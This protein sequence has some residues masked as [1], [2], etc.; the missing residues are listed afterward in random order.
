MPGGEPRPHRKC[1]PGVLALLAVALLSQTPAVESYRAESAR[2]GL[3][4]SQLSAEYSR[5]R[6]QRVRAALLARAQRA[7]HRSIV[8]TL[9][10]SWFGT[11]W[12]MDG[13]SETPGEGF[14]ACS[15]L[16]S[17]ILRDAGFKVQRYKLAQAASEQIVRSLVPRARVRRMTTGRTEDVLEELRSRG[18][19]LYLVG[20]DYHVGF[21]ILEGERADFCHS[22]FLPPG[23]VLCEP[24]AESTGFVSS[25]HVLG[26]VINAELTRA[27][28]RAERIPTRPSP[29]SDPG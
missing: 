22:S 9:I 5:A 1:L 2:L 18:D 3:L 21:I 13:I 17:T 24:A 20:L 7:L 8:D 15:Y 23:V 25:V 11:P 12:A 28:L 10:P 6:S 4:R 27:W 16:V 29:R 26:A 19:G 14:I